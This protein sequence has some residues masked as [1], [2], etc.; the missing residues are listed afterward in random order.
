MSALL[1]HV[2]VSELLIPVRPFPAVDRKSPQFPVGATVP[3]VELPDRHGVFAMA[4]AVCNVFS[5]FTNGVGFPV[6]IVLHPFV[7]GVAIGRLAG[8]ATKV[9]LTGAVG[10]NPNVSGIEAKGE[11]V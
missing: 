3:A 6:K 10:E 4:V 5:R 8:V 11:Y 2:D 1:T 7:G 9:P